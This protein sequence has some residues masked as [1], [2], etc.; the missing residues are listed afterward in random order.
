MPIS[1]KTRILVWSRAANRCSICRQEL[2]MDEISTDD[3]SLVGD[4]AHIVGESPDG[5]RGSSPLTPEQRDL[6][7]NLLLLCKPHHK[8][9]DDNEQE[10]TLARLQEIKATHERWVRESLAGFDPAKQRA[11]EV[12]ASYVQEW[13]KRAALEHWEAW[14]TLMLG[15]GRPSMFKEDDKRIELLR[16]WL[17]TRVWPEYFP[18]LRAAFENFRRVLCDLQEVFREHTTEGGNRL[19][20]REVDYEEEERDENSERLERQ[21]E[22]HVDLVFDLT[23]ELTRAAN[24]VCD[25]VREHLDPTFR[26]TEGVL[27][28]ESGPYMDGTYRKHRVAYHGDERTEIPYPGLEEFKVCRKTRDRHWGEGSSI[29]DPECRLAGDNDS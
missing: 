22:F 3:P 2:F 18:E 1:V 15:F 17:L 14:T 12:Y 4:V 27:L 26:M 25:K 20:T 21:C 29:D 23:V 24:Y 28:A 7:S 19:F 10:Y 9:I 13:I 8:L 11:V 6:Y 16:D 5:P